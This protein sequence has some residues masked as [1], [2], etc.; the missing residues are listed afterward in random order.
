MGMKIIGQLVGGPCDGAEIDID[1]NDDYP[2]IVETR[3]KGST[4]TVNYYRRPI[5]GMLH[6]K[7]HKIKKNVGIV[8]FDDHEHDEE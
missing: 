7:P 3:A 4:E 5:K 1:P 8:Y 6:N 2:D